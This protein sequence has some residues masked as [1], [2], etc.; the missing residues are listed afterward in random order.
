MATLV[1]VSASRAI[2][3]F[4]EKQHPLLQIRTTPAGDSFVRSFAYDSTTRRLEIF[5]RWKSARSFQ[6]ITAT[7]FRLLASRKDVHS[8]VAEWIK[9]RRITW[10]DVRTERKIVAS[11][12]CGFRL[13]VERMLHSGGNAD[14]RSNE[15]A[16]D[17]ALPTVAVANF[18]CNDGYRHHLSGS[19][20]PAAGKY[21]LDA[22]M[23]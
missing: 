8:A 11:M 12:L 9:R 1:C 6:P 15:A 10:K 21:A 16:W 19:A 7:M 13:V 14:W 18:Q 3:N 22:K 5:Y 4:R 20:I 17:T 2:P 23:I